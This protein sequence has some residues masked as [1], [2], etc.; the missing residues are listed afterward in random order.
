MPLAS[1]GSPSAVFASQD[2]RSCLPSNSN[3]VFCFLFA[4]FGD[5]AN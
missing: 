3:L 1:F 4:S 2:R 5:L